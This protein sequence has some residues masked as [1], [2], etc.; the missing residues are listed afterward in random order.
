MFGFCL[1]VIFIPDFLNG[2]CLVF[3][4]SEKETAKLNNTVFVIFCVNIERKKIFYIFCGTLAF[5]L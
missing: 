3:L 1:F 5:I 4:V 2:E